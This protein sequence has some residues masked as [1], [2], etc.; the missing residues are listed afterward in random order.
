M[1][2]RELPAT[3]LGRRAVVYVRQSTGAQVHENLE[4]Q[5]R[6]YA[7]GDVARGYGFQDVQV[8]DADLGRS[9]SGTMDACGGG[10]ARPAPR[11]IR[12][13]SP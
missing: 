12:D 1:M 9:A 8:I 11:R 7:L 6:Q 10:G 5:R 4:S 13:P 3:V 2:P